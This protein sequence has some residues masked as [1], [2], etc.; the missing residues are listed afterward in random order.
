MLSYLTQKTQNKHG[1]VE[2]KDLV[3]SKILG[4]KRKLLFTLSAFQ[5]VLSH[6]QPSSLTTGKPCDLAAEGSLS[7]LSQSSTVEQNVRLRNG[8]RQYVLASRL[9]FDAAQLPCVEPQG[10]FVLSP[11]KDGPQATGG[12]GEKKTCPKQTSQ[13]Q[14]PAW[15]GGV[16]GLQIKPG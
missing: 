2:P 10:L 16:G 4:L 15:V 9:D 7:L 14:C 8:K 11:H 1:N 6:I 13:K 3:C 5:T 12:G